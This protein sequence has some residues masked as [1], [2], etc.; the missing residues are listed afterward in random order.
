M[1]FPHLP[2]LGKGSL[3]MDVFDADGNPT[4]YQHFGNVTTTEQ[5]IKDDKAELYQHINAVP[6]MIATAVKKRALTLKLTG[7]DFSAD[8]M[9]IA[10]MGT[11]S[12]LVIEAT[13]VAGEVLASAT[14]TKKGKYFATRE[15]QSECG[16]SHCEPGRRAGPWRGLRHC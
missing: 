11:K 13:A 2:M 6:T 5:E 16:N 3:L 12:Q 15:T 7:T 4:G 1:P 10:L 14:V 8:H 9:A